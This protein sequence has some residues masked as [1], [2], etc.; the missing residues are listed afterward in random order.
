MTAPTLN[1]S[2]KTKKTAIGELRVEWG[3]SLLGKCAT[4]ER[5]KFAFR[6]RLHGSTAARRHLCRLVT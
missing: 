2:R 1:A 6:P 5:G 3:I 4:L